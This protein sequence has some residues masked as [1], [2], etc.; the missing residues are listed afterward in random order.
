[1]L[2]VGTTLEWIVFGIVI[3]GMLALDLFLFN[4]KAHKVP[5]REAAWW[6][7][8]WIALSLAFNLYVWYDHG[9]EAAGT[10]FAAYLL[11]KSLSVDNLFVFLV[12]FNYFG[13]T[14]NYRHRVLFWG[15]IGA[16]AMRAVFIGAGAALLHA[17]SWMTIVF[18]I[19]LIYTGVK[20][21]L[22]RGEETDPANTLVIRLSTRYLRATRNLAG[23]HF[24]TVENGVRMATPLF[25]ALVTIE[26]ADVMFAFDSV[27][28][29]LALSDD[30][31]II[32]T[33]NI[34]AILGLRAL[35]FLLSHAFDRLEYLNY[36]LAFILVFIGV[37]MIVSRWGVHVPIWVSLLVIVTTLLLTV[38]LSLLRKPAQPKTEEAPPP[39]ESDM[40]P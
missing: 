36:G 15:V 33:S 3:L 38:L 21:A 8:V 39:A 7:V 34:F 22:A 29:V 9:P 25:V 6:T 2:G 24:F 37:K 12:I 4:R 30:L 10:F 19:V 20:L 23:G 26:L 40:E 31:F 28:A 35:Y 13:I 27:P 17:F 5:L 14:E 16:L 18:G 32:Y 1:M 11:E